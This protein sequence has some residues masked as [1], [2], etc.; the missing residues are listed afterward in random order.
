MNNYCPSVKTAMEARLF[1][2]YK[3]RDS[4]M[5]S[6]IMKET[7]PCNTL[8]GGSN[9]VERKS[10]RYFCS[11]HLLRKS[12]PEEKGCWK[13]KYRYRKR[14]EHTEVSGIVAQDVDLGHNEVNVIVTQE[15]T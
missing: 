4:L 2:S 6:V 8:A 5:T 10:Q 9:Q 3:G 14:L 15:E 11:S 12:F 7:L 1:C 13:Y